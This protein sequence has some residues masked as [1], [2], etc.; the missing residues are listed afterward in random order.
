MK[1]YEL[2]IVLDGKATSSKKKT[3]TEKIEK[4]VKTLDGKVLGML[5]WGVKQLSYPMKKLNEGAFFIFQ[6]S[7]PPAS[8]K[9]IN[10]RLHNEE[11]ILRY[12][13]MTKDKKI[14]RI[15]NNPK[16]VVK[17]EKNEQKS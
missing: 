4:L 16:E 1:N 13:L 7:L 3:S 15:K 6:L 8:A 9:E 14:I 2:V 5:D 10:E 12:L 11:D 17:E